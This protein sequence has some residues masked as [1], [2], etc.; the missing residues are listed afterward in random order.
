MPTHYA[1]AAD[2]IRALNAYIK[3][4]RAAESVLQRTSAHLAAH[5]LSLSQFAVLEALYHLGTLS[6]IT[7]AAKL[8]KSTGN[9][10]SVLKTCE[11]HG[12]ITRERDPHDNRVMQ[13]RIT[14]PGRALLESILPAH[15]AGICAAMSVLSPAEQD[16]LGALCKRLGLGG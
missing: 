9:I 12:L 8:L 5:N 6:Q 13:V 3:L 4:Q 1:G 2:D 14:A 15:I 11:K 7:L 16:T 10:S